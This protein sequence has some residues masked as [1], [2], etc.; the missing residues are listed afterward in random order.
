MRRNTVNSKV[1]KLRMYYVF[2]C[3]LLMRVVYKFWLVIAFLLGLRPEL[4]TLF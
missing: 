4:F 3:L 2:L 1:G